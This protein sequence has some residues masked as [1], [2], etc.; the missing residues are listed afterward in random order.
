MHERNKKKRLFLSEN[1]SKFGFSVFFCY[2]CTQMHIFGHIASFAK[3]GALLL[4]LALAVPA[5]QAQSITQTKVKKVM[6]TWSMRNDYGIADTLSIDTAAINLP[7]R[8][9]LNDRSIAW[10]YNGNLISPAQSKIYFDRSGNGML[11]LTGTGGDWW[12]GGG[13]RP[14]SLPHRKVDFLFANAYEPYLLTPQDVQYYSTTVAYSDIAYKKGFTTYHAEN[15]LS[16]HF[17]GNVNK[18]TNI[19]VSMRYLN[20][21]G[22]YSSQ[23]AKVFSGAVFAS[24]DGTNYGLHASLLLNKLSN[25]EN[26]GLRDI[27]QLHGQLKPE[28]LP[29]Q[30]AGMSG[31]KHIAGYLDHH[32]SITVERERE[33]VIKGQKGQPDR[34][35]VVIDQIPVM[36]FNHVLE[37]NNSTK[38]YIEKTSQQGFFRDTWLNPATTRDTAYVLNIRNTVA[39]T[40]NEEFNKLLR[41]GATVYATNEFQRYAFGV[42]QYDTLGPTQWFQPFDPA[43]T[44]VAHL[45]SDTLVGHQWTNNTWVGGSI[46]KN[47]GKWIRF[48]VNGDI[49]LAGYKLGEFQVNGHLDGEFPLGPD[50]L[51]LRATAY[52]RNETPDFFTRHYRSNHYIWDNDFSKT[53]RF[54]AGGEVCYPYEWVKAKA[55]VGFENITHGIYFERDGRPVQHSGN[56]QILSA[57]A[58]VDV[59]TPWINLE[60]TVVWQLS[61]DSTIPLPAI[62]LYHNLYY[63][64]Y[65]FKRAVFA[66]IGVDM[67][68]HTAYYAPILNPATGQ[69]CIQQEQKIGNYPV[70]DAYINLYVKLLK[71]KFFAEWQHFNYYFMKNPAYLSMPDYAMNPAV[72]R[73][74]AHWFFWR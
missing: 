12:L 19:G 53:Y 50:S 4:L 28:D 8:D 9:V 67:R 66:Q 72:I 70:L 14:A 62:S 61:S 20:S 47:Q 10:A 35:T 32:Y 55:R 51:R 27:T 24:Y 5:A 45:M 44:F 34:D 42:G 60:N 73:A 11:S 58:R 39:V 69:F 1:R 30:L 63:H 23:E 33:T 46:Y 29:V 13:L 41:F 15:D 16:F 21:P 71:L 22:H 56:V 37:V 31:L 54:Y 25:F 18:R 57:D 68:Y 59:T 48:G 49:C 64:G 36:T 40:F 52:L 74:G 3:G 2:L 6:R 38:R 7:L 17:T 65:W 43:E 26:G